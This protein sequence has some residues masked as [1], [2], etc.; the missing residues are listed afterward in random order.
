MCI[1]DSSGGVGAYAADVR[2][3]AT[4]DIAER[5]EPLN[6]DVTTLYR[7]LADAD[8]TVTSG[9]LSGGLEPSGVRARYDGQVAEATSRLT[10]AGARAGVDRVTADRIADIGA[11]LPV[12]TGLI[13]RA[14]ANN[15]Q[16]FP[17]GWLTCG[18]PR[19]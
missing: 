14:R 12:Y 19:S 18:A 16:G 15:R 3:D 17:L 9:F 13:E 7:S 2:A 6:A 4:R 8:A 1:R 11:Q 5:I 10:Q